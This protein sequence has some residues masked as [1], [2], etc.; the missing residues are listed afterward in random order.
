MEEPELMPRATDHIPDMT[1]LVKRLMEGGF[2]YSNDGSIYFRVAAFPGYGKL[3]KIN[4]E[5]NIA[6]ARVDSDKYEKDS[7]RDFVLWKA[8]KRSDEPQWQTE[9]GRGRPG[10]HLECSAMSMRY[11]GET[12]DIHCGGVDLIF[13]HHENEIAQSECATGKPFVRYWLHCEF[14]Q[15][16][17]QKMSKSLGNY[18]TLRD[19]LGKGYSP[20][21]VR[22]ALLSVPYRRQM[23]F[24]FEGLEA[25][26]K[27]L[28][29]L[30]D[31][32]QRIAEALCTAGSS[33]KVAEAIEHARDDFT[34]GLDDDLNTAR[35]LGAI[36]TLAREANIALAEGAIGAED[37][38]DLLA[39]FCEADRILGVFGEQHTEALDSF[40]QDLIEERNRA[41]AEKD[42]ARSDEIRKLLADRG[43]LLEDTKAGTRWRRK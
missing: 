26:E 37:R 22:Y 33:P 39:F 25:A 30:V 12:F 3:S 17:D 42:F 18:F 19:L 6:G 8:P 21:A 2:A 7:V 29:S 15:V 40:V 38:E 27:T 35:A 11:L 28:G 43:V 5:G 10:W 32:R 34:Q 1:N 9:M 36:H 16:E 4:L 13:P 14:L 20:M 31:F 41:R 24:T 23:N